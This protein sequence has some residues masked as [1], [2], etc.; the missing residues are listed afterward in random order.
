MPFA[1]YAHLQTLELYG[2]PPWG[3]VR[4]P[5]LFLAT[6]V[7]IVGGLGFYLYRRAA[8]DPRAWGRR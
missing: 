7:T 5:L 2:S 8:H 4:E 1:S 3:V 6:Y